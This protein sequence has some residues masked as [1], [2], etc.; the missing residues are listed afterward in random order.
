VVSAIESEN[1]NEILL[2]NNGLNLKYLVSQLPG[3]CLSKI[4][5]YKLTFQLIK[6]L[7]TLHSLGFVHNNI[8]PSNILI[9]VE[10]H[11]EIYLI[12]FGE[13]HSY[14][15]ENGAHIEPSQ[16][17]QFKGNFKFASFN[18]CSFRI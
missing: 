7:K 9:G 18:A 4:S 14:Q 10:D 6:R 1:K 12:D 15:T 13:S 11:R 5:V 8:K 3:T 17:G 2:K 16:L